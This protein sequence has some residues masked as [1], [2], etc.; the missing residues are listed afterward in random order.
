VKHQ[1]Q[2]PDHVLCWSTVLMPLA[3]IPL[4]GVIKGD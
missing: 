3:A 4:F 1:P 2:K